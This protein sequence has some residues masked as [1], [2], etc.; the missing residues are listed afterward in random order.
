QLASTP[1]V[2]HPGLPRITICDCEPREGM[3]AIVL[4]TES[5]FRKALDYFS[6]RGRR[7]LA[8]VGVSRVVGEYEKLLPRLLKKYGIETRPYLIQGID[9]ERPETT[10]NCVH[11][12]MHAGQDERPDALYIADDNFLE[13]AS[14]GLI[15]AGVRVPKD[16]E[17]IA[18]CNFPWPTP[19]A[20]HI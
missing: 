9:L 8:V 1:V 7:R 16:V 10:R 6:S 4:P 3:R 20:L 18:H 11:M 17:V 12:L 15:N 13:H 19:S 5:Q 2:L 14:I